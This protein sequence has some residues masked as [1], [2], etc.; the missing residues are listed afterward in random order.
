MKHIE[1]RPAGG[2]P[3]AAPDRGL[4]CAEAA[5]RA[6]A[7]CANTPPQGLS[8]SAARIVADN[9]FTPFN[10]LFCAL[11]ACLAA[12][13]A[14]SD[15]LFLGV[16]ALNTLIGIVQE[17]RVKRAL[18]KVQVLQAEPVRTVRDGG[19]VLLDAAMLVEG[20]II[21][22]AAGDQVPADCEICG[23][24]PEVNEAL[25]TGEADAVAKGPGE[26]LLS[27]SFIAAGSCTARLVRVGEAC[28]AA[29]LAREA[30]VHKKHQSEM[31]RSLDKLVKVIGLCLVPL[32]L[33][34]FFRQLTVLHTGL[35]YAV[36]STVAAVVG[37][38]PEGLYLLTSVA[39][40]VGVLTLAR[41]RTL[42]RELSCIE[43]LA[44]VDVLCLD[45]TGTL[46]TGR[47]ALAGMLPAEETGE[48][49]LRAAGAAFIAAGDPA[50][51]NATAAALRAG[52]G[53][54]QAG[55]PVFP[56]GG[57][58]VPFS[59]AR[60]FTARQAADGAWYVLGAPEFVLGAGHPALEAL[61][62]PLARGLRALALARCAV[63]P[64]GPARNPQLLG[65]FLLEDTLRPD[66]AQTLAFFRSQG[67]Q[68]K[69]ISGD[70][71]AAVSQIARRAGVPNAHLAID[72]TALQGEE[73]LCR[74]A[75]Q[76]TVFGR[77]TPGQK[78]ILVHA[79]QEKGHTV[80]MTGDGVNDV[81]ALKDADCSIAMAAGS[82]AAR[83]VAQ[84]VLL[85]NDFSAMPRIVAEGRRVIN[86]IQR[87]ASLFLVKN[88]YS[89]LT[90]LCLLFIAMPYPFQPLQVSLFSFF[91]IGAPAFFLTFEPVYEKA[92]GRF[93]PKVLLAAAP[94]GLACT[95]CILAGMAVAAHLGLSTAQL[96]TVCVLSVAYTGLLGLATV[97]RPFTP[98]RGTVLAVTAAAYA[99]TL[100]IAGPWL[101]LVGLP[102]AAW[103]ALAG[104]LALG[105]AAFWLLCRL[106]SFSVRR[107]RRMRAAARR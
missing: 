62:G 33:A 36:T 100:L 96:C 80:A 66:A 10:F 49:A 46:T 2:W 20:D 101:G 25:L 103:G 37:M 26:S 29:R 34:M 24:A 107:V 69:V 21:R 85:D 56:A 31:M 84:L 28:Y 19:E 5:R 53:G 12:V 87:A 22:L 104:I 32:G 65:F 58:Q 18:E 89:F 51:D 8:K 15:L 90:A 76:Y 27:G 78:R 35:H 99:L 88:I 97:C 4:T 9:L 93:L 50:A 60:K 42:V 47:M 54:R 79:L 40:A 3:A 59:S 105:T 73:A 71:A 57:G 81:L 92:R 16:I 14:W 45:K 102:G 48:E 44:R 1:K 13:G 11:G 41:R 67:V 55:G 74:A 61:A 83:Q 23:G 106:C 91:C 95:V 68:I 17:L 75:E 64:E 38:V 70:S 52:L 98:L 77:M 86:N 63:R 82:E 6:A 30:R 72:G 39:L 7:G 94:G 43:S